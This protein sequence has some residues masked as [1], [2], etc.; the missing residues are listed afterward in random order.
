MEK[1]EKICNCNMIIEY[2]N[3]M[4]IVIDPLTHD[5]DDNNDEGISKIFFRANF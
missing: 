4:E 1:N 3:I 2:I 5:E